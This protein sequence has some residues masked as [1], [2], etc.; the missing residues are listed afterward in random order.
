MFSEWGKCLIDESGNKIDS[1]QAAGKNAAATFNC[2]PSL[3][4]NI[5]AALL[6]FAGS[7]AIIFIIISG[8]RMIF[9]GEDA[10]K[11]E[12]SKKGLLFAIVGLLVILLSYFILNLISSATGATTI[13][14]PCIPSC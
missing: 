14:K 9:G 6:V 5:V 12:E 8:L 10:K 11:I 4:A 7:V 13:L 1:S 3:F 2:L